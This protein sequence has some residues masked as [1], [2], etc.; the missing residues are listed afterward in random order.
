MNS[1]SPPHK[2]LKTLLALWN[3][4]DLNQVAMEAKK[5]LRSYPRSITILNVLGTAYTNLNE[6][7]V[8]IGFYSKALRIQP[9]NAEIL[10]NRGNARVKLGE[11]ELA[12]LDFRRALSIDPKFSLAFN[13]LGLAFKA[14]GKLDK[15]AD[16]FR[17]AVAIDSVLIDAYVHLGNTYFEQ[18]ETSL[19]RETFGHAIGL[20]SKCIDAYWNLFGTS[21]SLAEAK[22]RITKCLAVCPSY[23][24]ARL[25]MSFILAWE[26]DYSVLRNMSESEYSGHPYIRSYFW[27]LGLPERPSLHFNRWSFYDAVTK[28]CD[29]SRPFY[30]FGVWRGAS[31]RYLLKSFRNGFGFDTFYGLPENWYENERGSYNSQ[32]EIPTL[33]GGEFIAGEFEQ[34]LPIFF[35]QSRKFASLVNF[36]ADLYSATLCALNNSKNIIDQNT[37]LIF[38]EMLM[39]EHWEQDEF[40]ALTEFCGRHQMRYRV[41]AVCLFSKQVAVRLENA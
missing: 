33:E 36:D 1:T 22:N 34:T 25:M 15:A 30:E 14:Q 9:D 12:I 24:N 37:I 35:S 2:K 29:T 11:Y 26:G 38:D 20:D 28:L 27:I 41:V 13:N 21:T 5:L 4:G 31:F 18:A 17:K 7:S 23:E 40:R 32:G 39:N 19:A 6:P 10:N 16:S 3:N 8:A